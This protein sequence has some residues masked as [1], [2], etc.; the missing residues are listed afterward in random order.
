[1]LDIISKPLL[2]RDRRTCCH[3]HTRMSH[4]IIWTI[5]LAPNTRLEAERISKLTES[6]KRSPC[7]GVLTLQDSVSWNRMMMP[8][9]R[10]R[11]LWMDLLDSMARIAQKPLLTTIWHVLLTQ[12]PRQR[13]RYQTSRPLHSCSWQICQRNCQEHQKHPVHM[14]TKSRLKSCRMVLRRSLFR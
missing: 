10:S 6:L 13:K 5:E 12:P 3:L 7:E 1:M 4:I 2:T 14:W 8:T 11:T 9:I